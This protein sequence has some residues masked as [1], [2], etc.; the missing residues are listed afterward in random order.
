MRHWGLALLLT[1][2]WALPAQ[3][4]DLRRVESVG[5][6]GLAPDG[7]WTTPPR[8]AARDRA[9]ADAV[10]RVALSLL[11]ALDPETSEEALTP[12]L[13]ADPAVYATRY[14]ILEDRGERPALL[15]TD[16]DVEREYVVVVEVFVDAERVR[17]QLAQAGL[18][19]GASGDSRSAR[20]QVVVLGDGYPAYAAARDALRGQAGVQSVTPRTIERG[21]AVFE[22]VADRP[23]VELLDALLADPDPEVSLEPVEAG[24]DGF[25]LRVETPEPPPQPADDAPAGFDFQG[26]RY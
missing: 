1:A 4:A 11:P 24:E 14:R 20:L 26:N 16:P 5:A 15:V 2:L 8:D 22:V 9:L 10:R 13:G 3:A 17:A 19:D 7:R 25:V 23:G 12:V 18:L 21:R 6:V